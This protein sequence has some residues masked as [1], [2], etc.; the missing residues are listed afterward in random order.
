MSSRSR[1]VH[2]ASGSLPAFSAALQRAES[3]SLIRMTKPDTPF[4]PVPQ[5]APAA[6]AD[7]VPGSLPLDFD[8]APTKVRIDALADTGTVET[9]AAQTGMSV[10]RCLLAAVSQPGPSQQGGTGKG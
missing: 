1:G 6:P 7:P 5:G 9:A 10:Q 4:T 2:T 3:V 8:S